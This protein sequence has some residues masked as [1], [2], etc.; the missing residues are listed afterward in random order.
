MQDWTYYNPKYVKLVEVT[1][2]HGDSLF[3]P[4]HPLSYRG[5]TD[6]PPNLVNGSSIIDALRMGHHL[7]LYASSDGHDGHSGHCISHTP[8]YVGHQ[9]PFTTWY[10]RCDKPYPGGLTACYAESLNRQDIFGSIVGRKVFASSDFGRSIIDFTINGLPTG[11]NSTLIVDNSSSVRQLGIF[12]AQDG[13]PASEK[14]TSASTKVTKN[15]TPNWNGVIEIIKN[16]NLISEIDVSAPT[17]YYTFTDSTPVIGAIYGAESCVIING[18]Y[19]IN[20]YSDNVISDPD[21][22]STGSSDFYL[23]RFVGNNG[24]TSY[25]GPIWVQSS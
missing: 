21:S 6:P 16:G 18:E 3:E 10:T 12:L 2:V 5:S 8:A 9:T 7:S 22:L 19:Y 11:G 4:N 17:G 1:S 13:A 25:I 15:W 24:R 23:I 14:L 20:K